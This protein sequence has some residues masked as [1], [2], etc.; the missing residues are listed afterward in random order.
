MAWFRKKT[1]FPDDSQIFSVDFFQLEN[2]VSHH[3]S[4]LFFHLDKNIP[5]SLLTDSSTSFFKLSELA[6]KSVVREK[7]RKNEKSVPVIL[8]CPDGKGSENFAE[9]LQKEGYVNVFFLSGGTNAL[10]KKG[11]Q[12][13]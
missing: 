1:D 4:F 13:E 9:Q 8:V 10:L 11:D 2:L 7:L 12:S 3:V 5:S 6:T